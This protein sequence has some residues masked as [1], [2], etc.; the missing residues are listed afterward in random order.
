MMKGDLTLTD[1]IKLKNNTKML[2]K[3]REFLYCGR[4]TMPLLEGGG[5]SRPMYKSLFEAVA[6]IQSLIWY[7]SVVLCLCVQAQ[8]A[9]MDDVFY[10]DRTVVVGAPTGSG[11][12]SHT[13]AAPT[14]IHIPP[15]PPHSAP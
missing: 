2:L 5:G 10:S 15:P 8:S 11:F 9:V 4:R 12:Y 3:D 7:Q 1:Y 6:S 13:H 14:I